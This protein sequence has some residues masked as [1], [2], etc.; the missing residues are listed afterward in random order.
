MIRHKVFC[1][2]RDH[3][4]IDEFGDVNMLGKSASRS[5]TASSTATTSTTVTTKTPPG[6]TNMRSSMTTGRFTVIELS[7]DTA[8]ASAPKMLLIHD[9]LSIRR[10]NGHYP[11]RRPIDFK[12]EQ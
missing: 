11:I 9:L 12:G 10:P 5:A 4:L 8:M 2:F 3:G 6:A 1:L 7:G